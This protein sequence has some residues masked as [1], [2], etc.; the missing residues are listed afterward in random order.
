MTAVPFEAE[1]TD[2]GQPRPQA[3]DDEPLPEVVEAAADEA[4]NEEAETKLELAR[5]YEEMG[6]NEGALELLQE[7]LG[8]GSSRQQRTAQ[9][10]IARLG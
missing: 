6:D 3:V 4:D 2:I 8:E 9:E 1:S 5:A 10:M 7:V